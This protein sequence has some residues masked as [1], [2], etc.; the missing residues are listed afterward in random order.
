MHA[1]FSARSASSTM[2]IVGVSYKLIP[3]FT[4][5]EIQSRTRAFLSVALLNVALAGSFVTI[6]CA[7]RGNSPLRCSRWRTDFTPGNWPQYCA[8]QATNL[9]WGIKYFLTAAAL[10]LL[11]SGLGVVL[12]W[13]TLPLTPVWPARNLYGFLGLL[14][15]ITFAIIGMLYKILPFLV[16]FDATAARSGSKSSCAGRYAR[17]Q[18]IGFWIF[19]AGLAL[20]T[21]NSVIERIP[22]S[23]AAACWLSLAAFAM[24][25]GLI[26]RLCQTPACATDAAG[27]PNTHY[28][29]IMNLITEALV[30]EKLKEVIDPEI[31]CNIVDLGLIYNVNIIDN[32]VTVTMTLTTRGVRCA[33]PA[34]G[35]KRVV[36][37][38]ENR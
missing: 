28:R 9:D 6:R 4:L 15:V 36:P 30:L 13:P 20:T 16:W 27:K 22:R 24:N 25:A 2:L 14:G 21:P 3:M 37:T 17:G 1:Y 26:L 29:L 5:S 34:G 12:S 18:T 31:G 23:I 38:A 33:T 32:N 35:R 10:L 7:A 11:V 8:A 19:L